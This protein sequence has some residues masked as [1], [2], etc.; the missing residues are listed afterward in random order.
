MDVPLFKIC[1]VSILKPFSRL[2]KYVVLPFIEIFPKLNL[3]L[4]EGK[5]WEV[6]SKKP[7]HTLCNQPSNQTRNQL[8]LW[9][10]RAV[11]A[12]FRHFYS[13]TTTVLLFLKIWIYERPFSQYLSKFWTF[14]NSSRQSTA[15]QLSDGA[16]EAEEG[17]IRRGENLRLAGRKNVS[18]CASD[19]LW[20]N[21]FVLSMSR[22][23]NRWPAFSPPPSFSV[24]W[25]NISQEGAG[26]WQEVPLRLYARSCGLFW[27]ELIVCKCEGVNGNVTSILL[28]FRGWRLRRGRLWWM[29]EAKAMRQSEINGKKS[30]RSFCKC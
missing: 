6:L 27:R 13:R 19:P 8:M 12:V 23:Q 14:Q 28:E 25:C 3:L 2:L 22:T 18:I 21:S 24:A 7:N 4:V 5:K 15:A 10:Y 16:M 9:S 20:K 1:G 26:V 11:N 17:S 29:D 30:Q